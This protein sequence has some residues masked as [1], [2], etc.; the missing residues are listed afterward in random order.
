MNRGER[1]SST[2][3]TYIFFQLI[4]EGSKHYQLILVENWYDLC[5]Q[6]IYFVFLIDNFSWFSIEPFLLR[7]IY[8][9]DLKDPINSSNNFTKALVNF[10]FD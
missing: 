9:H 7:W 10:K 2:Q 3:V 8:M 6:L 4:L 1:N 5:H